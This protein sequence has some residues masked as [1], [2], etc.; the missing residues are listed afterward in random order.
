MCFW[1]KY[2]KSLKIAEYPVYQ[3]KRLGLLEVPIALSNPNNL[4]SESLL[5]VIVLPL[6]VYPYF[7]LDTDQDQYNILL[8][9][10]KNLGKTVWYS[11]F[12][13]FLNLYCYFNFLLI[14]I[15][16]VTVFFVL[17]LE[18][19]NW[20]GLINISYVVSF[21]SPCHCFRLF[22]IF[23]VIVIIYFICVANKTQI[24]QETE[25]IES[26]CSFFVISSILE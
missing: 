11:I 18:N 26:F 23:F 15:V 2:Q 14:I 13:N 16:S 25:W 19:C 5:R 21:S 20:G 3:L 8:H 9:S 6:L 7:K 4:M 17:C 24:Q 10:K 22:C 12:V 1:Q